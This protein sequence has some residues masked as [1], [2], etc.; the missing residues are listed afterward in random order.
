MCVAGLRFCVGSSRESGLR[1][2]LAMLHGLSPWHPMFAP[3]RWCCTL[4]RDACANRNSHS[5]LGAFEMACFFSSVGTAS[6]VSEGQDRAQSD[7]QGGHGGRVDVASMLDELP[8]QGHALCRQTTV[9]TCLHMSARRSTG[10]T[11]IIPLSS[12]S[13]AAC[14]ASPGRENP[15]ERTTAG[16]RVVELSLQ[17]LS[18]CSACRTARVVG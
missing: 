3:W 10:L 18:A 6:N 1:P 13:V 7:E 14:A 8:L 15:C 11:L 17:T 5:H 2:R 12:G 9:R 16:Q 4:A